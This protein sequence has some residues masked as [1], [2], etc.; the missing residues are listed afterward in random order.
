MKPKLV[1]IGDPKKQGVGQAISRFVQFAKDKSYIIA[2]CSIEQ[3]QKNCEDA[4]ASIVK[5]KFQI[6]DALK[7]CDYAIVFGGD[8]SI[9]ATSRS[10]ANSNIPVIGV[11]VGKL[12]FLAEL[13]PQLP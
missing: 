10:V 6:Q 12:G 7:E 8:G 1:I 5:Q 11:N 2:R 13:I 9:I 4:P 3:L